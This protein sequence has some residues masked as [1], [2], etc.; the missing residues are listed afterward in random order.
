MDKNIICMKWGDKFD[1]GYVNRLYEMVE[2]NIT[3][4]HRFVCFTDNGEGINPNVEIRPI[5]PLC[6]DGIPDR[7][8]KKLTVFNKDLYDLE[9]TALFLDLDIIVRQSLDPFFEAE[10]EFLIIKDWDF[11]NDIIGNSSVFRFEILEHFRVLGPAVRKHFQNEPAF[12]TYEMFE[13]GILKY[14]DSDWCVSFKRCCLHKFPLCW[15][16]V[17]RDPE[18]AKILIFHGK[19]NPEQAYKGYFGKMGFRMILPTKW[20]DKYW[21]RNK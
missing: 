6:E 17:P 2:K 19:P 15:F 21:V 1:A 10:G 9:G 3:I 7:M 16:K 20:L 12:L 11:P 18:E 13:K 4:P 5:P 14:W 8:W